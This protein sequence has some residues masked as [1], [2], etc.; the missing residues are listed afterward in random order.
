MSGF[1][2][3]FFCSFQFP[4]TSPSPLPLC[5]CAEFERILFRFIHSLNDL[6]STQ[7]QKH[8]LLPDLHMLRASSE[9]NLG[10]DFSCL[11]LH[12]LDGASRDDEGPKLFDLKPASSLINS[13]K[14]NKVAQVLI[15]LITLGGNSKVLI[16]LRSFES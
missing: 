10:K 6:S 2:T 12:S 3:L 1:R 14:G 11:S 13:T 7:E 9:G 15:L 16:L 4:L 5:P 8:L